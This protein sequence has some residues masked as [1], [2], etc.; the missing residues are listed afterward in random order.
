MDQIVLP[1]ILYFLTGLPSTYFIPYTLNKNCS[2]PGTLVT[3]IQSRMLTPPL[4]YDSSIRLSNVLYNDKLS[5]SL[6]LI[7][8]LIPALCN[9]SET[10]YVP[11]PLQIERWSSNAAAIDFL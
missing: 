6:H 10:I 7:L 5:I 11:A 8:G 3:Q 1:A 9:T 4:S 2:L